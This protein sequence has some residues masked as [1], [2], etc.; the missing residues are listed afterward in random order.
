MYS[1]CDNLPLSCYLFLESHHLRF[2]YFFFLMIRPPPNS[3]LFPYPPPFRSSP[4]VAWPDVPR[5]VR[6]IMPRLFLDA[7]GSSRV[8]VI[9]EDGRV[10]YGPPLRGGDF[11]V[12]RPFPTTLYNWRLQVTL[13][14]AQELGARVERRRL[15]E[16]FMVGLSCAVVVAGMAVVIV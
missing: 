14:S 12:G 16:M 3:T 13:T 7:A 2:F 5:I 15:L 1:S 6:D 4:V 10:V 9:D 8:N 11:T